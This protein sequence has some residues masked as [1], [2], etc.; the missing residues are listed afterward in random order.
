MSTST[1]STT[2]TRDGSTVST[3]STRGSILTASV[4]LG[5]TSALTT[6]PPDWSTTSKNISVK[7]FATSSVLPT[8]GKI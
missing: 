2:S 1:I 8:S 5:P 7:P 3:I 6:V 4:G